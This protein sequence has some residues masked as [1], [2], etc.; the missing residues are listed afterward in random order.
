MMMMKSVVRSLESSSTLHFL[1]FYLPRLF[2]LLLGRDLEGRAILQTAISQEQV[3]RPLLKAAAAL[4]YPVNAA[5]RER[6]RERESDGR[7]KDK[8]ALE[9]DAFPLFGFLFE[10]P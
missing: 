6:E 2:L 5:K 1:T 8:Y 3:G 10:T 9:T 7:S 4:F